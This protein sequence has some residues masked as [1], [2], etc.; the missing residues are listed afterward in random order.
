MTLPYCSL[1]AA[2]GLPNMLQEREHALRKQCRGFL[3]VVGEA[4]VSEQVA[5]AGVQEQLRALDG[6]VELAGGVEVS[7]LHPLVSLHHVDLQR[8][9]MRPGAAEFR[10]RESG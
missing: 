10:G 3:V 9:S 4:V 7:F 1:G 5:V 6:F 8:D 2:A